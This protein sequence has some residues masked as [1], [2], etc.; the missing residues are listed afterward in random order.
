M[1]ASAS[2]SAFK[3]FLDEPS[4]DPALGFGAY[5]QALAQIIRHSKP[6]F[7][8]GVFGDWGSGKTTLMQAIERELLN[9]DDVLTV[10]F[11]AWRYEREDHLIV[12]LL[13][14]IRAALLEWAGRRDE[15]EVTA[16]RTALRA[17]ASM[18][19]AG[20]AIVSASTFKLKVP[21][22]EA[23]LEGEKLLAGT[24][25]DHADEA[26]SFYFRSFQEM[27]GAVSPFIRKERHRRIVVFIDDLDRCLPA[28]ALQVLES[29]KLF[30]DQLGFV[31]VVG[32]DK[33]VVERA[34]ELRYREG[35]KREEGDEEVGVI[36][37]ADYIKKI[38]QVPFA[39]PPI[40]TNQIR[41]YFQSLLADKGLAKA[42][43]EH[44]ESVVSAHVDDLVDQRGVNPREVKRLLNAY[45]L[46]LKLLGER[47]EGRSG[48]R[49]FDPNV[50]LGLQAMAFRPDWGDLYDEVLRD[51]ALFVSSV[52]EA[53]SELGGADHWLAGSSRPI[54]LS[55]LEYARG[56]GG[57]VLRDD[58]DEYV[59][60]VEASRSSDPRLLGMHRSIAQVSIGT[61]ELLSAG[62][63]SSEAVS[64]VR[65]QL[66]SLE[67]N[68]SRYPSLMTRITRMKMEL[69]ALP[70]LPDEGEERTSWG[71]RFMPLVQRA[72]ADV[73]ELRRRASVGATSG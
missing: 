33:Q 29:L 1:A 58:L 12:P 16:K 45:V 65:G 59:S 70:M 4:P 67:Q 55:F 27:H 7:A 62:P 61:R 47:F 9:D 54:P 60:S 51:P 31:F 26:V 14:T 3:V 13:D 53:L 40:R 69:E 24:S 43:R 46:Q 66:E 37:G 25:R 5:A 28:N 6:Q 32:L 72:A 52:R 64:Q 18:A 17:A 35:R 50:V 41:E 34:I 23:S 21:Y 57:C 10:W 49:A 68:A 71:A 56:R 15:S 22:V 73:A 36:E 11:T 39:L 48:Q 2:Y 38:I 42:Q 19:R 30:F 44:F 8:V 63:P 20:R